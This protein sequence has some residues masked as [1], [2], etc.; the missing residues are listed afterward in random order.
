MQAFPGSRAAFTAA[1]ALCALT[2][3]VAPSAAV[4]PQPSD[5]RITLEAKRAPEHVSLPD[6]PVVF[7]VQNVNRRTGI[8]QALVDQDSW[9]FRT[10]GVC[11]SFTQISG[12]CVQDIAE[13]S[14]ALSVA[15]LSC[16]VASDSVTITYSGATPH[17]LAF[18]ESIC[19]SVRFAPVGPTCLIDYRFRPRSSALGQ[20]AAEGIG[21]VN[22]TQVPSFFLLSQGGGAGAAGATG[23]SG[24]VLWGTYSSPN[25]EAAG[26]SAMVMGADVSRVVGGESP[27]RP[28]IPEW[29]AP[30]CRCQSLRR[31]QPCRPCREML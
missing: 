10:E 17:A 14:T 28:P 31:G 29:A 20:F 6:T 1:F 24:P 25:C 2:S 30:N 23:A 4:E 9:V 21:R 11:G 26:P 7:C 22:Q 18:E 5:N 15:D 16:A 8:N 13:N 12:T 19:I 3:V 27:S